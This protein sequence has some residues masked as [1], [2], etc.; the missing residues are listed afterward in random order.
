MQILAEEN[1]PQETTNQGAAVFSRFLQMVCN[2]ALTHRE[3][4]YY[5]DVLCVTPKYLSEL[6][7]KQTA[8]P[9]TAWINSAAAQLAASLLRNKQ[10]SL[11]DIAD[12]M[13]FSSVPHFCR[14]VKKALGMTPTEYRKQHLK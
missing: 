13:A 4:S 9:A 5:A 3:V 2:D 11:Q 6:C 1:K 14:F 8:K 10:Y 7:V 12:R